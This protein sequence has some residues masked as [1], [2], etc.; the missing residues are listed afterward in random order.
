MTDFIFAHSDDNDN[1]S[2]LIFGVEGFH[3]FNKFVFVKIWT[4]LNADWIR[5]ASEELNLS[6][7]IMYVRA[8]KLPGSFPDPQ[9]MSWLTIVFSM[10][11]SGESSF[12]RQNQ[13]FMG[14]VHVVH[15]FE[16]II[17]CGYSVKISIT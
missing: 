8:I 6:L 13:S 9:H 14:N 11:L 15:V 5:Y 12:V 17:M 16:K 10:V 2:L 3:E 4:D 1:F 7:K